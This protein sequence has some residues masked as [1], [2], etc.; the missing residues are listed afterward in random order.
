MYVMFIRYRR[1]TSDNKRNENDAQYKAEK[2]ETILFDKAIGY[3]QRIR[4][5]FL[6]RLVEY[7]GTWYECHRVLKLAQV[8]KW[9]KACVGAHNVQNR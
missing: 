5:H 1:R 4:K 3:K 2:P 9:F 7:S 6:W 8:E